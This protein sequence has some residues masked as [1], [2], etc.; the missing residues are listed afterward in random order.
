[1]I[2]QSFFTQTTPPA[3]A[4]ETIFHKKNCHPHLSNKKVVPLPTI[5]CNK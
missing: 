4:V 2:L 3:A 1:M 5:Y